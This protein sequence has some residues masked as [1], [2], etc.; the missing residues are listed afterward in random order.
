MSK[1][2]LEPIKNDIE[3]IEEALKTNLNPYLDLVADV[4]GHLIFAG[5]KRLRPVL[6]VLCARMC[7][8]RGGEEIRLSTVFEYVHTATL[9]HDDVVDGAS[10]R[11]GKPAAHLLWDPATVVLVGDFLFCRACII[12]TETNKLSI[13]KVITGFTAIM[14]EGEIQQLHYKKNISLTEKQYLDIINRKTAALISGACEVGGLLADAPEKQ[15]TA[16]TDYG[17]HLGIAFQMADDILDYIA[18]PEVSGKAVGADLAE[19]KLTLPLISALESADK[20]TRL[21]ME[22][23]ILAESVTDDDFKFILDAIKKYKGVDYTEKQ[24]QKHV[25]LARK[26]LENFED[27]PEKE[28]LLKIAN[29]AA[30]RKS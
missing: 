6:M 29:F 4:A 9:L 7:G 25:A 30:Q 10:T 3:A 19:G 22:K 18:D 23:I 8:Y 27:C 2:I 20:P 15:I 28:I 12:A 14:A 16:L 13:I 24:A 1:K 5:G 21:A 26:C 11:R 17:R